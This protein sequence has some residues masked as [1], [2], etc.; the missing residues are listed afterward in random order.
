MHDYWNAFLTPLQSTLH[1]IVSFVP[2]LLV[3]LLLLLLFWG[4]A[5]LARRIARKSLERVQHIPWAVRLLIVR[6]IYLGTLFIGILVALA[7]AN[8][9]VTT[10]IASLGVAGFALGF[11]LKDILENFIAGI[12]LLFARPFEM[13]DQVSLGEFEGTVTDIQIRT[14]SLRTYDGELVVIPNSHVYTNPVVNHTRLGKRRYTVNFDTSLTAD[15]A[16]VEREAL[17][18]VKDNEDVSVDPN[19]F[20][21][22]TSVD[23]G[24]DVLSWRL[25]YW[26][27]PTKAIEVA[28]TS[29]VLR[30]I[31]EKLYDAGVPTPTSTS[32]TIIQRPPHSAAKGDAHE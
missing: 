27:E 4:V 8:I 21:R 28:T 3:A 5:T 29:H 18:T 1:R 15:A 30:R 26:A 7:A 25:Y 6:S 22:I 14:T 11:A 16:T 31:K 23:S 32:A 24:N 17:D 2:R 9:N 20:V 19:P 13:N 12:L 10:L